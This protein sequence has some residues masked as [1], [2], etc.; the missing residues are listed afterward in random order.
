MVYIAHCVP[1]LFCC[2]CHLRH[3]KFK[4]PIQPSISE[5]SYHL[6]ES[7]A[8]KRCEFMLTIQFS[9]TGW[10]DNKKSQQIRCDHFQH[11]SESKINIF[12]PFKINFIW[13]EWFFFGGLFEWFNLFVNWHIG[14]IISEDWP[15]FMNKNVI[16][17]RIRIIGINISK[18]INHTTKYSWYQRSAIKSILI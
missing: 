12:F 3:V 7:T 18:W 5:G 6:F 1:L 8:N 17:K 2:V 16:A 13:K 10:W 9:F 11:F 4:R 15:D 14:V